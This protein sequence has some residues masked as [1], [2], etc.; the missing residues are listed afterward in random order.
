MPKFDL[1]YVK[2]FLDEQLERD[3]HKDD[4]LSI[5]EYRWFMAQLVQVEI[6]EQLKRIDSSLEGFEAR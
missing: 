1:A 2:E 5:D 3:L 6:A 4:Y